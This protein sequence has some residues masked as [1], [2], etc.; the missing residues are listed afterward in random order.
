MVLSWF[1][2]GLS[3]VAPGT[4]GSLGALPLGALIH[5]SFGSQA[6]AVSAVVLFLVGW[7]ITAAHLDED[8]T[9]KDPQW[10]VIDEVAGQWLTLAAVPLHPLDCLLAFVLFRLFDIAKPWPVSWADRRVGGAL[11]IMLDDLLAGLYA[12]VVAFV[13][14]SAFRAFGTVFP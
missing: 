7:A 9:G 8:S 6:L 1:G 13:L 2:C 4:V 5:W 12:A 11:G 3:P 14:L 10:I